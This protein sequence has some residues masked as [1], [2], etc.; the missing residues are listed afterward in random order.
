MGSGQKCL[1]L[2]YYTSASPSPS[3]L[4]RS[5]NTNSTPQCVTFDNKRRSVSPPR[6]K[7]YVLHTSLYGP[8]GEEDS[9]NSSDINVLGSRSSTFTV[10]ETVD[11]ITLVWLTLSSMWECKYSD[12]SFGRNAIGRLLA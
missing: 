9:D 6:G 2:F 7:K 3:S 10:V 5:G 8:D 4:K 12:C 1:R 11:K